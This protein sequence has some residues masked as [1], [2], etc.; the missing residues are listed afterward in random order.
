MS[1]ET[2]TTVSQID[3]IASNLDQFFLIVMGCLIFCKYF[4]D[5]IL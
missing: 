1:T 4:S 5:R 2:P 3:T